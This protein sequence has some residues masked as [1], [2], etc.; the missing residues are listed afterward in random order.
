[1][2]RSVLALSALLAIIVLPF[3]MRP[4]RPASAGTDLAAVERLVIITPHNEPVRYE[5]ARA[6]RAFMAGQ[7]RCVEID[8]RSPGG[9]AE[10]AR[11]L[12]SE[13]TASFQ[14]YWTGQLH[15]SWSAKV[16]GGFMA[17]SPAP[18]SSPSTAVVDEGAQARQA[19]LASEVGCG[20]DLLFGGGS[21]DHVRHAR[22]GRLVDA[23]VVAAHPDLFG[24]GGIPQD[25]GGQVLWDRQGRWIGACLASFGICFNRDSLTR[26]GVAVP[27]SWQALTDPRLRGEIALADPSKSGSAAKAFETIIQAEMQRAGVVEGWARAIRL[28]R[29]VG[30]NARYFTDSSS[31]VALDV[32]AGDAAVGTCI[33]YYGRFQRESLS[34]LGYPGRVGYAAPPGETAVDADPIGL[35]R[36]A[37][38]RALAVAF[39][40]FVLS[41][42]GQKLWAFRQGTPGGP[43]RYTLGRLPMLRDLYGHP[44]DDARA[45]LGEDPYDPEG[46]LDYHEPWTGP[47]F[48]AIAFVVRTMCV[49]TEPELRSAYGALVAAHFPPQATALFDDLSLVDYATVSGPIQAALRSSDPLAE[50]AWARRLVEHF[51]DVYRRTAALARAGQ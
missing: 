35:L 34:A 50:A 7:G 13:Y 19:F 12:A 37:P 15:R 25:L 1:M 46:R 23:G 48:G 20:L 18:P 2:N 30:G 5:F 11:Y 36:G 40:E 49:E 45:D 31:K 44:F 51:R 9:T 32:N 29:R 17:A 24:P 4:R 47:L 33:D 43:E 42:A 22:A 39:I 26:L 14:H 10:I 3:V 38:H 21:V 27:S 28:I 8:W 41:P 16:A 6:F